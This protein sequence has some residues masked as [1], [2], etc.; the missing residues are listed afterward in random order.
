MIDQ[1][2]RAPA[3]IDRP[4]LS[5]AIIFTALL[6]D[7]ASQHW[8]TTRAP[9]LCEQMEHKETGSITWSERSKNK[10]IN[11][12]QLDTEGTCWPGAKRQHDDKE[13]EYISA[14]TW[15]QALLGHILGILPHWTVINL[16]LAKTGILATHCTSV[17]GF[18]CNK[19]QHISVCFKRVTFTL[20][21]L[22]PYNDI[23]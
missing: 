3:L 11:E 18:Y 21:P 4:C 22:H 8:C 6:P 7:G 20:T 13:R 14:M 15:H 23:L 5:V 12:I 19:Y 9:T 2:E 10:K 16:N 17:P 1:T